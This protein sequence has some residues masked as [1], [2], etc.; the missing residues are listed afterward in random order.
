MALNSGAGWTRSPSLL[1]GDDSV[2]RVSGGQGLGQQL[3][4]KEKKGQDGA[5][6]YA[7]SMALSP[8]GTATLPG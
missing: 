2:G 1:Q 8:A 4:L 6:R 3:W 7:H 5:T